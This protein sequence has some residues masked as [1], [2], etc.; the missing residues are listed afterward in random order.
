[1]FSYIR[2]RNCPVWRNGAWVKCEGEGNNAIGLIES[3]SLDLI[4]IEE[5]TSH[6]ARNR[7]CAIAMEIFEKNPDI[8]E[9]VKSF[10]H[11]LQ[12][13]EVKDREEKVN[14]EEADKVSS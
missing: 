7:A 12:P 5:S 9:K 14:D 4:G 1:M 10:P 11:L 2:K 3:C 6:I 8:V 13:K